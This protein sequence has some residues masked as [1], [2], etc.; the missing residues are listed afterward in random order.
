LPSGVHLMEVP[1]RP[2]ARQCRAVCCALPRRGLRD[3]DRRPS[4][5]IASNGRKTP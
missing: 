2:G 1:L 4:R 3:G 5:F